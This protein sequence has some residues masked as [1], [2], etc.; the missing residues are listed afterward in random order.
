M[1]VT[2]RERLEEEIHDLCRRGE[3]HL[4]VDRIMRGYG[5]D[6]RKMMNSVLPDDERAQD[7]FG[8]FSER[9]LKGL[10]NFRWES[11]FRTWAYRMA[12]NAC[13]KQVNAASAREIAVT[14]S[15]LPEHSLRQRT[16]TN[17]WQ[18]TDVKERFRALRKSL[19]SQD[20]K[21][22]ALRLDQNLPWQEVARAMAPPEEPLRG[23]ALARRAAAMRQQ[24][25][26]IKARLRT[27]A[28][29]EGLVEDEED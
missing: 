9:L 13:L 3:L 22:L 1:H 26:R 17:P 12:R 11:S 29:Q 8:L 23:E 4:A 6:I 24:F 28:L 25:Q 7:A 19:D 16:A 14:R 27:L 15:A 2:D 10:K 20:Q 21:L 18:R 5:R